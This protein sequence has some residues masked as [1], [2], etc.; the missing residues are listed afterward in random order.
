ME[1]GEIQIRQTGARGGYEAEVR[2]DMLNSGDNG[3]WVSIVG[4]GPTEAVA[5]ANL[6]AAMV[7][8]R[9]TPKA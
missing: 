3:C 8:A 1:W 6:H 7:E 4:W 2:G 5:R 9:K